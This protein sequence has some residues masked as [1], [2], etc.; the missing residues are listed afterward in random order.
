M[1]GI[2]VIIGTDTV[3][4]GSDGVYKN[5]IPSGWRGTITPIVDKYY[6]SPQS[7]P[8]DSPVNADDSTNYFE[9]YL[10]NPLV[11]FTLDST[12]ICEGGSLSD[13]EVNKYPNAIITGTYQQNVDG[14]FYDSGTFWLTKD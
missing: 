8:K 12:S 7:V 14:G 2:E 3:E 1:Q 5:E 6:Y 13:T 10:I 4:T 11:E 9:A